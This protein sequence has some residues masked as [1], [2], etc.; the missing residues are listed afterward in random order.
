MPKLGA[1][2]FCLAA[3]PLQAQEQ[4]PPAYAFE[5]A[6]VIPMDAERALAA[7]TVVV[8]G[9]RIL[10]VGPAVTTAVPE[11]AVRIDGRGKFLIPGL[12]EMH[13][14]FP[15]PQALQQLG[16]DYADRLLFLS[17]ANGVTTV[18][19]MLGGPRDLR[20]RE[21][22]A[23]GQRLGPQ[24]F[25]AG[26]S[27]NG[28]SVPSVEAAWR[29]VSEQRAAGYDL[30]KIHP[31]V[32]RE[33]FDAAVATARR[34]RIAFAGHV[35]AD[36]GLVRALLSGMRSVEHLDGYVEALQKDGA[37]PLPANTGFFGLAVV[38]H[39]DEAKIPAL[40]AA[41][42][43]AGTWNTPTQV[44]IENLYSEET[45]EELSRRPETRYVPRAMLEQ[46]VRSVRQSRSAPEYTPERARRFIALRRKLIKAL[47]EAGAGILLGADAPQIFNVPGFA[48][49]REMEALAAAGLRPY[50]VLEAG[51]RNPAIA[52]DLPES[53]GTIAPGK[54]ADLVLLEAD[55][56]LDIRNVRRRAGV[57][58]AGRWL[59]ASEIDERLKAYATPPA[60]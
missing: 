40:V 37:P 20:V 49:L 6:T 16:E 19:G 29:T 13:G 31:G 38:D 14:H 51:T 11:G 44:L 58:A 56:L 43:A 36:V 28:N 2:V 48:T 27:L 46:W 30:L 42:R 35:P 33:P 54:R 15:G 17:L 32:R 21:E 50:E 10:T 57:M 12:A 4:A 60:P 52:L 8:R 9:R 5:G 23:R 18:R 53:F 59:P 3:A 55:P 24:I 25:V 41:T 26:P 1:I 47:Q 45:P 22:I 7:H 39:V 34:E